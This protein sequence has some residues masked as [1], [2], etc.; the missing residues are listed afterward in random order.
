MIAPSAGWMISC[1]F[2]IIFSGF[3]RP[4]SYGPGPGPWRVASE[5]EIR[6][7]ALDPG[8]LRLAAKRV[9]HI[10]GERDCFLVAKDGYIMH[11]EYYGNSN[12]ESL[13]ESDSLAKTFTA[14]VIGAA[15][16]KGLIDLDIPLIRYNVTPRANWNL[17][18]VDFWP[19]VTARHLLSQTTGIGKHFPGT[20]FTYD[21]DS[22]IQHLSYLVAAVS[23]KDAV[24]FATD[25]VAA[26]LGIPN[27]W[28]ADDLP[29]GA[30]SAGGGQMITCRDAARFGQ[31]ISN[32][33]FWQD[34]DSKLPPS[35]IISE[36]FAEQMVTSSFPNI[37]SCYSFLSWVNNKQIEGG[38]P[39]FAARWGKPP[40][41]PSEWENSTSLLGDGIANISAVTLGQSW[42]SSL[43]CNLGNKSKGE[44]GYDDSFAMT[45]AYREPGVKVQV[46]VPPSFSRLSSQ[47]SS[48]VSQKKTKRMQTGSGSC[49]CRCPPSQGFGI[50]YGD[51][52]SSNQ[53]KDYVEDAITQCPNVS[54]LKQCSLSREGKGQDT[55]NTTTMTKA[56]FCSQK[57][58]CS[59]D[60][61]DNNSAP[62]SS[63]ICICVPK[64]FS[65][66]WSP[67]PC[68]FSPYF[69][70]PR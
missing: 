7:H 11:E 22:Y 24:E 51:V 28:L 42:G 18:G 17:T 13:V 35:S 1:L 45:Q 21:S 10:M 39:C 25:S 50:C 40:D 29:D 38:K 49:S 5:Q 43:A 66:S 67:E 34:Y 12:V 36:D 61:F 44:Y 63:E 58:S 48:L 4:S 57:V 32:G 62:F 56:M 52:N 46:P 16:Q 20:L 55:C 64:K 33:G 6:Q 59:D 8:Q 68:S 14:L 53:C 3:V 54:V 65:C 2:L 37:S 27:F 41:C 23:G 15:V 30:F 9:K 70:P 60:R 26:P 19:F 69:P 47:K 31:L